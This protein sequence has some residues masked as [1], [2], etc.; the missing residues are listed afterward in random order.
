MP[1]F[2][3]WLGSEHIKQWYSP[4]EDWI[5]ECKQRA[6]EYAWIQHYIILADEAP[7]GFCQYYPYWRSGE[8]WNDPAGSRLFF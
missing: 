7:I 1:L 2:I 3:N 6:N 5:A 8:D 4:V